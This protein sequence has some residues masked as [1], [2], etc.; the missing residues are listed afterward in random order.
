MIAPG[1]N[2]QQENYLPEPSRM[3]PGG[4][5]V[6][7]PTRAPVGVQPMTSLLDVVWRNRWIVVAST[8][9]C[10]AAAYVNV[11]LSTP[12]YTGQARL[13][14][15]QA[16]PKIL[17][18]S[19][20]SDS[21]K[22]DTFLY[23]Q[24]ELIKST[25]IL[26]KAVQSVWANRPKAFEGVSNPA[27]FLKKSLVVTVGKTD[28]IITVALELAD[29][30]EATLVLNAVVEAY[31]SKYVEQKRSTTVEVVKILKKEKEKRDAELEQHRKAVEEFRK[32]NPSLSIGDERGSLMTGRCTQ[33][34]TELIQAQ[35]DLIQAEERA[36]LFAKTRNDP[37]QRAKLLEAAMAQGTIKIDE[38]L[39][40]QIHLQELAL[41]T[42]SGRYDEGHPRVKAIKGPLDD[43]RK[44]ARQQEAA[45]LD[46]YLDGV[47]QENNLQAN[48]AQTKVER[49]QHDYDEQ[50][51]LATKAMS[52]ASEYPFLKESLDRSQTRFDV[53]T[54]R[55]MDLS[56][57]EDVGALNITVVEPATTDAT[58][59]SPKRA[60]TLGVGMMLGLILGFGLAWLRDFLDHRL[61]S[62][63]EITALL[64]LP[65][66]G[67]LPHV[68]GKHDRSVAGKM[69]ATRPRS[70]IAESFRTLR[71]AIYFG[72]QEGQAKTILV[73][74]PS[75]G[76]GKSTVAS[77]LAI[78]MAQTDQTVLLIEA[79][80]RKPAQREIFTLQTDASF[81]RVFTDQAAL[82]S[83]I[84]S[85]D[86]KGLSLLPCG[87]IPPN[88]VE[89]LNSRTFR[90]A[91]DELA[92]RYD[93]III[94]AP[95]VVPVADAR[96]LGALCDITLL[97]LRAEKST[98]R[99]SLGARDE[100]LS[101]GARILGVVV[102]SAPAGKG[103]YGYGRYG[104][105]RYGYGGYGSRYG[106]GYG[107]GS[108]GAADGEYKY[109][110]APGEKEKAEPAG[111]A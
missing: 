10:V 89:I 28:N 78:A 103:K 87:P 39:K 45:A 102:N 30:Q 37:E 56:V 92:L 104:Y 108:D 32:E 14:V 69:V 95:P 16:A 101:L 17:D 20:G 85:T 31:V 84:V 100:L 62:A 6:A 80:F 46:A 68:A 109:D 106:Y 35:L 19:A 24:A 73:T 23:T 65:L 77:N 8:L 44:Q 33:L 27:V 26:D 97:V 49:L 90:Q 11:V 83:A 86:I 81:S 111:K 105:G 72:L 43:L 74:S 52:K 7:E 25:P 29:P 94:D 50:F 88:P 55:I 110:D 98:R 91:L 4:I 12:K 96:V 76:D 79:D 61:R 51:Q 22:S 38:F 82:D 60:R 54:D 59:T 9:V 41:A 47:Q 48:L 71:T 75:P 53:V 5:P 2:N 1:S 67:V 93:K 40:Q 58:P 36:K 15:E 13:L 3:R 21:A 107:Y 63:D 64:E 99:H 66:L 70:E 18:N 34:L 42:E 57:S